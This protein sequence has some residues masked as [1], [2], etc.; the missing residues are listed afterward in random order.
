MATVS[1][2]PAQLG[3]GEHPPMRQ[4]F[5]YLLVAEVALIIGGPILLEWGVGRPLWSLLGIA[6]F[7][8]SFFAATGQGR[9][10]VVA[11][12]L[13]IPAILG[14]FIT[15][16]DYKS[17]LLPPGSLFGT[18]FMVYITV[19]ILRSVIRTAK[20]T[21]DTL[22]GAVAAYVLLGITCG[23]VYF[24]LETFWP[25]SFTSPLMPGAQISGPDFVFFSFVT[26]TTIGYGD[27]VPASGIAK[28]FV[29]LEAVTGIMYPAVMIARMIALHSA[30]PDE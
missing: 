30:N 6:V 11:A 27:I 21:I 12:L 2:R 9:A 13:G 7:V 4:R 17:R 20:V 10:T 19:L 24:L 16:L 25:F 26:L 14:A 22:Y 23:S 3:K 29:I 15:A 5:S 8:T 1:I 28:S 18:V